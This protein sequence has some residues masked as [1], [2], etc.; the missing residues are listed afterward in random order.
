ML[1]RVPPAAVEAFIRLTVL[2]APPVPVSST[3]LRAALRRGDSPGN[4][5]P[6]AVAR[7][8][9]ERSLYQA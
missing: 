6:L 8:I 5:L 2:S 9:E 4:G 1:R 7:H 3:A